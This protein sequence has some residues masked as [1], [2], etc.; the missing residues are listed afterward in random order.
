MLQNILVAGA[1]REPRAHGFNLVHRETIQT[2]K[3]MQALQE[4][5]NRYPRVGLSLLKIF[6]PGDLWRKEAKFWAER[7]REL[8]AQR[9]GNVVSMTGKESAE[10]GSDASVS[11][12]CEE[13]AT[14]QEHDVP[15]GGHLPTASSDQRQS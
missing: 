15:V 1:A 5:E 12:G 13:T 4:L 14:D 2:R 10:S 9:Y 8:D 7:K 11:T 6:F 3:V